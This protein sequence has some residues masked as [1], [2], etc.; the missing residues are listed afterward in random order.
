MMNDNVAV[1]T[2]ASRGIGF[3]IASELAS[4]G[5]SLG[6]IARS[7]SDIEE[8]SRDIQKQFPE[9]KIITGAFDV[10]DGVKAEDFIHRVCVELGNISVLVNNAGY[11]Q[12]GTSSSPID[13]VQRSIDVHFLAAVRF[14]R[15]V[16]P[17][18]KKLGKGYIFNIASLC[19]VEAVAETGSY[20]A[21]KFALVGYSSSLA[22]ELAPMGIKVTALCPSWVKTQNSEGS[23][24]KPEQMIQTNDLALSVRYLLG[25]GPSASVHEIII[26]CY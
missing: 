3:A 5:Y 2:G 20:S 15:A 13:E 10:V 9:V 8:A 18:M 16:L 22:K 23:P 21:S 1:V 19:G 6:L 12:P 25:L 4:L 11:Y 17:S 26:R 7:Q 24:L 14:V